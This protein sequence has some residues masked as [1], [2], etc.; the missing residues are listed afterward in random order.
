MCIRDSVYIVRNY[1][2]MR[3]RLEDLKAA[4]ELSGE[5]FVTGLSMA[6]MSTIY[7]IGSVILQSSINAVSYTHLDVYK[8]QRSGR[9]AV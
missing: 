9:S 7:S 3:F 4:P 5:M 1:A 6:M 2:Q 8:R